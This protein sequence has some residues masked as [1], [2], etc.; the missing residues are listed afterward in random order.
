MD[1]IFIS[2]KFGVIVSF[3]ISNGGPVPKMRIYNDK[4]FETGHMRRWNP[5]FVAKLI[6]SQ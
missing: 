1:S 2:L 3:S 5:L 4:T 6:K